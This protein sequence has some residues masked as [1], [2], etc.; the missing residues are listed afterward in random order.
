M[1]TLISFPSIHI[2]DCWHSLGI[3]IFRSISSLFIV[4][5]WGYSLLLCATIIYMVLLYIII[6][7]VWAAVGRWR[8][9]MRGVS[10]N[11][12]P[13]KWI[14]ETSQFWIRQSMQKR[15][16]MYKTVQFGGFCFVSYCR[17]LTNRKHHMNNNIFF[18]G[19]HGGNVN[20]NKR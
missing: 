12:Q 14:S 6:S 20:R 10:N 7:F 8:Q 15:R 11:N 5:D 18:D 1:Y 2:V 16:M 19:P 3:Y 9:T 13:K 4:F 17:L